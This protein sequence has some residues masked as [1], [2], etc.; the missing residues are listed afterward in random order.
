MPCT[1]IRPEELIP[2]PFLK[3]FILSLVGTWLDPQSPSIQDIYICIGRM[4]NLSVFR[5]RT[6]LRRIT[7]R[8]GRWWLSLLEVL[9][10]E[11][12]L[13]FIWWSV[14]CCRLSMV[15]LRQLSSVVSRRPLCVRRRRTPHP[16]HSQFIKCRSFF[17]H[18]RI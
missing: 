7:R 9:T 1:L 3:R 16:S 4:D 11:T 18:R 2:R 5:K 17:S 12:I 8:P 13:S 15:E 10:S 14:V 6:Q